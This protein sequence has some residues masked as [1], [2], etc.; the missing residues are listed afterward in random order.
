MTKPLVTYP[1]PE[2]AVVDHLTDALTGEDVTVG[3]GLPTG[4]DTSD[5]PHIQVACDGT[6]VDEHP[7]A[8]RATIRVVAW[9]SSTS[10]AKRL[11]L[12][13][14]GHLLTGWGDDLHSVTPLTGLLPAYDPGHDAELASFTA[15]VRVRSTEILASS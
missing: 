15:R 1:D 6:P 10:E 4:W 8:H 3:V 11:A 7:I 14:H 12:L 2:R 9:S 13:A 5:D